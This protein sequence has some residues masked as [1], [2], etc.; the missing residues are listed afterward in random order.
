MRKDTGGRPTPIASISA[1]QKPSNR[2][3]SAKMD[4]LANSSGSEGLNPFD[5][6]V[7]LRPLLLICSARRPLPRRRAVTDGPQLSGAGPGGFGSRAVDG[8]PAGVAISISAFLG[9]ATADS[10]E[11][12]SDEE[13]DDDGNVHNECE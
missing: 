8:R 5:F 3:L 9:S 4:A 12:M 13:V 7:R 1:R 2:E 11:A 10:E 6:T